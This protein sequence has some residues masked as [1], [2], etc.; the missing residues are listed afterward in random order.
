MSNPSEIDRDDLAFVHNPYL[1]ENSL[2][3]LDEVGVL[4][5]DDTEIKDFE[6]EAF[7][8]VGHLSF[9]AFFYHERE[10]D[11]RSWMYLLL[12]EEYVASLWIDK[13]ELM[14]P[15]T[16]SRVRPN[17]LE[18]MSHAYGHCDVCPAMNFLGYNLGKSELGE[19]LGRTED[20]ETPH[21]SPYGN[22]TDEDAGNC[23]DCQ[24][25][26]AEWFVDKIKEDT[27]YLWGM[28]GTGLVHKLSLDREERNIIDLIVGREPIVEV[29]EPDEEL[30]KAEINQL[31]EVGTVEQGPEYFFNIL[32]AI[33]FSQKFNFDDFQVNCK[34]RE[35]IDSS[36]EYD[37]FL[38][39]YES[40]DLVV[41]ETTAEGRLDGSRLRKKQ[42]AALQLQ[43]I[44]ARYDEL[45]TLYLYVTTAV[46]DDLYTESA[47]RA[48]QES[49]EPIKI[50]SFPED[51]V[52]SSA[53]EA[54]DAISCPPDEFGEEIR[55]LYDYLIYEIDDQLSKFIS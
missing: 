5:T 9:F 8:D 35:P 37:V 20:I 24:E 10:D 19:V 44:Q 14:A 40:Q 28:G 55:T 39:D 16:S 30:N 22:Y 41:I 33:Y 50:I 49:L 27:N 17:P 18:D 29:E 2:K 6:E 11:K 53:L 47:T 32:L 51:D 23:L 13:T 43:A 15:A 26:M 36:F 1:K 4:F 21:T 48:V 38:I 34:M 42:N 31:D 25:M 52:N 7:D 45:D 12:D 3:R 46:Y 54:T